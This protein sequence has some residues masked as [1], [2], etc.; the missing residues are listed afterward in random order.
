[1][2][3]SENDTFT[4]IKDLKSKILGGGSAPTWKLLGGGTPAPSTRPPPPLLCLWHS[5]VC[6]ICDGNSGDYVPGPIFFVSP[7][8]PLSPP[9]VQTLSLP[10]PLLNLLLSLSIIP[11]LVLKFLQLGLLCVVCFLAVVTT[12]YSQLV[13]PC[14][15]AQKKAEM[16][17]VVLAITGNEHAQV[18]VYFRALGPR[19]VCGKLFPCTGSTYSMRKNLDEH[20]YRQKF[21]LT[22]LQ[23][24]K[25][26]PGLHLGFCSRGGQN[27]CFRIPGGQVLHAVHYNQGQL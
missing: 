15:L 25:C 9:S 19:I 20:R 1:M 24:F 13:S 23:N 12:R 6:T 11:P 3:N 18:S 26:V 2:L 14:E 17:S 27:S 8:S 16:N 21:Q 10:L 4:T 7:L 5:S 22:W